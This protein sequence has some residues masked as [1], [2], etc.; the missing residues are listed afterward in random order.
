MNAESRIFFSFSR[1]RTVDFQ[2]AVSA[3]WTDIS[4]VRR[5]ANWKFRPVRKAL[6]FNVRFCESYRGGIALRRGI[7]DPS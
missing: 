3:G 4:I 5:G 7:A 1:Y 2:D 6:R